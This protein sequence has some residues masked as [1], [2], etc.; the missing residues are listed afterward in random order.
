MVFW[1]TATQH[2]LTIELLRYR[3]RRRHGSLIASFLFRTWWS[4]RPTKK[5]EF[6]KKDIADIGPEDRVRTL[7]RNG[8]YNTADD[9]LCTI[10]F[11]FISSLLFSPALVCRS[12]QKNMC[13]KEPRY[14]RKTGRLFRILCFGAVF[15]T[16]FIISLNS[17]SSSS[18]ALFFIIKCHFRS[19]T[20]LRYSTFC[21]FFEAL[22]IIL[23]FSESSMAIHHRIRRLGI[24]KVNDVLQL[25][26]I[27]GT[28]DG[29]T[30]LV[31]ERKHATPT[32]D[33]HFSDVVNSL[34]IGW[35]RWDFTFIATLLTSINIQSFQLLCHE[36]K[37]IEIVEITSL[38]RFKLSKTTWFWS[39]AAN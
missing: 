9:V 14:R 37:Y 26:H 5:D 24:F 1:S 38:L 11:S 23:L 21:F 25:S 18:P 2:T 12:Q 28:I 10:V 33:A 7:Y 39:E 3:R 29:I 6:S 36:C 22:Y 34:K 13:W 31:L 32:Y 8:L 4:T 35:L 16:G 30:V 19:V 17:T 15:K 27:F 20:W